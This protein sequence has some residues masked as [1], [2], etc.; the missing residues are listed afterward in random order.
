M[1]FGFLQNRDF[2]VFRTM[3]SSPSDSHHRENLSNS[4]LRLDSEADQN[5]HL[6]G[7]QETNED[8][9]I[10]PCSTNGDLHRLAA[11]VDGVNGIDVDAADWLE[12]LFLL[13]SNRKDAQQ[14]AELTLT[15]YGSLGNAL[16]RPGKELRQVLGVDRSTTAIVSMISSCM[17]LVLAEKL[18]VRQMIRS[19]SALLEFISIDLK[20]ADQEISRVL[21]LDDRNGLLKEEEIARGTI[22]GMRFQAKDIAKRAIT[23]RA[24]GVILAHNHLSDEATPRTID[25]QATIKI[26]EALKSFDVFL[27]DHVIVARDNIFSMRDEKLI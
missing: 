26:K 23:Y 21:Y 4:T 18:P 22:A 17:K 20:H 10:L 15:T 24:A 25:V 1:L 9:D 13:S 6:P 11:F 3:S 8:I 19:S 7:L 16:S 27:H 14:L 2:G 12:M 5:Q